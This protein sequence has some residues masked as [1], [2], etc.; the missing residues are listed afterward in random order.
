[1]SL[2]NALQEA[3]SGIPEC[4]AA[5][6]VDLSTGMLLGIKTVDSHPS[7]VLEILAAATS[8]LFQGTN[9]QLIENYL[10]PFRRALGFGLS[11]SN[12]LL[13]FSFSVFLFG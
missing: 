7:E 2:D 5:G 13:F 12:S 8:D 1:M 11:T 10:L 6:Y 3:I 4:V 9:V